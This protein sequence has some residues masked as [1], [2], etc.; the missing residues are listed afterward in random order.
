[1][2]ELQIYTRLNNL[3]QS[4]KVI[5]KKIRRLALI[6]MFYA[7]GMILL[8]TGLDFATW[9]T[10]LVTF[11]PLMPIIVFFVIRVIKQFKSATKYPLFY[12]NWLDESTFV[13]SVRSRAND[14]VQPDPNTIKIG[15]YGLEYI[16]D[17]I[18]NYGD[19]KYKLSNGLYNKILTTSLVEE[20]K[21]YEKFKK[22]K[23]HMN[24]YRNSVY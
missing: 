8:F 2:N 12:N 15:N 18:K 14:R 16:D 4:N 1:M 6:W 20:I 9:L 10:I 19:D 11:V 5:L 17:L 23:K 3:F 7:L 22:F 21:F 24:E 13:N